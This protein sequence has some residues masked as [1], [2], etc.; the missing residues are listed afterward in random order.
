MERQDAERA[1]ALIRKVVDQ[2]K[3]DLVEQNWGLLWMIHAFVN[4]GAFVAIGL[5][6]EARGLALP[7]YLA[8]LAAAGVIDGVIML[9]LGHRDRGIKSFVE[10]QM[11]GIWGTFIVS[12]GLANLALFFA[13]APPELFAYVVALTSGISF[14]MMGVVFTPRFF[15][16]AALFALALASFPFV[17]M[18][19]AR[20][21]VI[22]VLWWLT[23]FGAG[24]AMHRIRL[25]RGARTAKI[26]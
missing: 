13:G 22:G 5:V 14:A 9:L 19:G 6:V 23:L 21:V 11:H 24:A 3:D 7:F 8:P 17:S 1:L 25:S 15:A 10:W 12:T 20:W 26:L 4:L 16:V 18:T 2:T